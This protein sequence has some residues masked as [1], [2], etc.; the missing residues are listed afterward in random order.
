MDAAVIAR[1]EQPVLDFYLYQRTH[2]PF[3]VDS[4]EMLL[5]AAERSI[6]SR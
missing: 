4:D 3:R 2:C 5:D 1:G 6:T